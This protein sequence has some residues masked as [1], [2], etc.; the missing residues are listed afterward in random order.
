MMETTLNLD[1]VLTLLHG[2]AVTLQLAA[3]VLAFGTAGGVVLGIASAY[4]GA[5][6]RLFVGTLLYLARGL[7]LLIQVFA[8]FYLLPLFGPTLDRFSTAAVALGAFAAMTISEIV[9]G[10]L[11]AIPKG[12]IEAAYSLGLKRL[13]TIRLIILPQALRVL[14]APLIGQFV[15]LVKAT[16]IISLLGVPELMFSAREI[17]ERDLEGFKV[18]SLVWLIYTAV[19]MPLSML[20]RHLERRLAIR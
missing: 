16:S 20:G 10:G 13:A 1:T 12:Q 19:C 5:P 9:R 4:G 8:I 2:L 14:L 6:A 7:P 18:M 17:I 11:V 3:V 15:F